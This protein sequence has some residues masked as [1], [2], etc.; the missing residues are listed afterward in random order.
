[1]ERLW[2]PWRLEYIEQAKPQGCIFCTYPN[3]RGDETDRGNL[4]LGR[5]EHAFVMLNRF[6]YTSGHL[7]V[8]PRRHTARL[9]ELTPEELLDL[10]T[11]LQK[12][13]RVLREAYRCEGLNLG[14]N[15]G[16]AAGA[17][18]DDHLHWHAV[19]RWTGDTNFMS[20]LGDVR[21]V[22]EHLQKTWDK[23]RPFYG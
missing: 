1:M 15:L 13:T 6:P 23:L 18:I 14:M 20:T 12:T 3:E 5:T 17:G 19:P 4:L 22:I 11:L 21:V 16:R 7:L 8:V 10:S 2:A 9:D